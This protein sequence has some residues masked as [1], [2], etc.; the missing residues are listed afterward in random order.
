MPF[1]SWPFSVCSQTTWEF[2]SGVRGWLLPRLYIFFWF[3]LFF[4][5]WLWT[6]P[7]FNGFGF[8]RCLLTGSFVWVT[9]DIN[10]CTGEPRVPSIGTFLSLLTARSA[11]PFAQWYSG[12]L[13]MWVKSQSLAKSQKVWLMNCV[14]QSDNSLWGIPWTEK[15]RFRLLITHCDVMFFSWSISNHPE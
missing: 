14:P 11:S 3:S 15:C 9:L 1:L 2:W 4:D 12:L 13:V 6:V 7:E 10:L 5:R 8:S